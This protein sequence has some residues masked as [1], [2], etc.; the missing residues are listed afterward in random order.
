MKQ[1]ERE[2]QFVTEKGGVQAH[3]IC[4]NP[5][6]REELESRGIQSQAAD[7]TTESVAL[8][9]VLWRRVQCS[10]NTAEERLF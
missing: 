2:F 3:V 6:V 5:V 4:C 9:S 8:F 1:N 7:Q 10:Y